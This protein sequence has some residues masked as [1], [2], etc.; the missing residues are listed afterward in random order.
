MI[1]S[2]PGSISII[3]ANYRIKGHIWVRSEGPPPI[4]TLLL[5]LCSSHNVVNVEGEGNRRFTFEG[6]RVEK[7]INYQNLM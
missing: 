4:H 6:W 5:L 7:N 3:A 2:S 1:T